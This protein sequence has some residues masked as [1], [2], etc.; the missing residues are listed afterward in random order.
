MGAMTNTTSPSSFYNQGAVVQSTSNGSIADSVVAENNAATYAAEAAASA[1][2]AATS[3]NGEIICTIDGNGSAIGTGVK[4]D[5]PIGFACVIN[6]MTLVADQTG[7][8]VIDIWKAPLT[9]FPPTV[10]NSITASD[11]PTL[12]SATHVQDNGLSG[13]T[14]QINAG[15][16]L[17]FNV[18]SASTVTRVALALQ[19]TKG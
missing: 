8:I 6:S 11:P 14:T 18:N 3:L 4:A 17:R 16:V 9:S 5:F 1:A 19:I 13:W 2:I 7:S 12:A 15:D 10:S